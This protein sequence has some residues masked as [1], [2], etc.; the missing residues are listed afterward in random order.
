MS[1]ESLMYIILNGA[2]KYKIKL[3]RINKSLMF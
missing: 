1:D 3:Q 2:Q